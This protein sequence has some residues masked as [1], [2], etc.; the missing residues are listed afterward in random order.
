MR[1]VIQRVS[2]AKVLVDGATVGEIGPGLLVYLGVG[3]TDSEETAKHF[4]ER[5]ATLRIFPDEAGKMNLDV[6]AGGSSVLVVSQFT[7][8]ADTAHGHRPSFIKAG[9]PEL[10]SRLCEVF[11]TALKDRGL[12][13]ATGQFA[14]DMKVEATNDGP[15]NIVASTAE[16][17]WI[18]DA[19]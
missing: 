12:T 9:P 7:L 11:A 4:A 1:A 13:V 3:P 6:H 17:E 15:I 19:G 2:T 16:S 18:T 8:Y 5:I 14:A 10:G